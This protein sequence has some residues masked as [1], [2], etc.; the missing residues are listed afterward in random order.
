MLK[1]IA[2]IIASAAMLYVLHI[3]FAL[4]KLVGMF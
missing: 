1:N 4:A 2:L 3:E